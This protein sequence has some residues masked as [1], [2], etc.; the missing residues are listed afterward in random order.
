LQIGIPGRMPNALWWILASSLMLLS[1]YHTEYT[2]ESFAPTI[3]G[4]ESF[5]TTHDD[6]W[7]M[8]VAY[9]GWTY[10]DR[11]KWNTPGVVWRTDVLLLKDPHL[12]PKAQVIWSLLSQTEYDGRFADLGMEFIKEY[13]ELLVKHNMENIVTSP[14]IYNWEWGSTSGA[15]SAHIAAVNKVSEK[16]YVDRMVYHATKQTRW[17]MVFDV[18]KLLNKYK[19]KI[20]SRQQ[21]F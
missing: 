18:Y 6:T 3:F 8:M 7:R 14:W 4:E 19:E 20:K 9:D 1:N 15:L 10:D 2:K 16:Q 5:S 13:C 11:F 12:I 17:L 21:S